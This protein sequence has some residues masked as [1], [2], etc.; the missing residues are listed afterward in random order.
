MARDTVVITT[1]LKYQGLVIVGKV[2]VLYI[3]QV[4]SG[5]VWL[6]ALLFLLL[7]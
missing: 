1:Y 6:G 4:G 2:A 5:G 3:L 7:T